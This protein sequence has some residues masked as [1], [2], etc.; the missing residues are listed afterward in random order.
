[1][2]GALYSLMTK[3]ATVFSENFAAIT[4]EPFDIV[5]RPDEQPMPNESDNPLSEYVRSAMQ[6]DGLT[7]EAVA[8]MSTRRKGSPGIARSTVQ[9]I[10]Q[11][12]TPNPGIFTLRDL[13]WGIN[14]PLDIILKKA[15]GDTAADVSSAATEFADLAELYEQL[16][17]PERRGIKRYF[18]QVLE[19]EMRRILRQL[20]E[21]D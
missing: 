8:K 12:K 7:A 13:A 16:P 10:V 5:P 2:R 9:Q 4:A 1:M 11:G 15:L 14:K 19:R 18:L 3:H 21:R 6:E 20:A 17:L